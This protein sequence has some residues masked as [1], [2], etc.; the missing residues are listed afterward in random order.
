M[1]REV[2]R[3]S[4]AQRSYAP[5]DGSECGGKP[6]RVERPRPNKCLLLTPPEAMVGTAV[7][8]Q[9]CLLFEATQEKHER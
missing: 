1:S 4:R 2:D 3:Q 5:G 6:Q 9:R 7:L 8:R